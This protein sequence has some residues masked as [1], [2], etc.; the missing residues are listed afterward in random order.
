[1]AGTL[2]NILKLTCGKKLYVNEIERNSTSIEDINDAFRHHAEG[3]FLHSFYETRPFVKV[4]FQAM[5]VDK[6]SAVLGYPNE[7][8]TPM[9]ADHR[10]V[11]KFSSTADPNYRTLRNALSATLEAIIARGR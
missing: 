2:S 3:L 5:I 11:C 8:H 1:M 7:Q 6:D 9:D 4:L 10:S